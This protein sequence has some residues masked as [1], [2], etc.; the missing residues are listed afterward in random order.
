MKRINLI[1]VIFIVG[2]TSKFSVG[3]D[4]FSY[5]S[6]FKCKISTNLKGLVI[7]RWEFPEEYP[8]VLSFDLAGKKLQYSINVSRRGRFRNDPSNCYFPPLLIDFKKKAIKGSIFDNNERIKI[9]THCAYKEKMGAET[10]FREY[11]AYKLSQ[12]ICTHYLRSRFGE[13][14]YDNDN[15]GKSFR[16]KAIFLES[17]YG[18]KERLGL[19]ALKADSIDL[20]EIDK[21]SYY[22][23]VFFQA[24]IGNVDWMIENNHNVILLKD[25]NNPTSLYPIPYDL[26]MSI[27][28]QPDYFQTFTF[29]DPSAELANF[30]FE[31]ELKDR[32]LLETIIYDLLL[33]REEINFLLNSIPEEYIYSKSILEVRVSSFYDKIQQEDFIDNLIN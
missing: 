29:I 19:K 5:E 17:K 27:I 14:D 22:K 4:I 12:I 23:F 25:A 21:Y 11:I 24:L 33:V 8:G 16:G 13:I 32:K 15:R 26:D 3:Q 20:A 30:K 6:E 31:G 7:D 9:V 10:I 18:L 1:L 2:L 28:V